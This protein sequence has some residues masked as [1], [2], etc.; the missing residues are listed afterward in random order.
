MHI[1]THLSVIF[2]SSHVAFQIP[3]GANWTQQ[4]IDRQTDW[5]LVFYLSYVYYRWT[6]HLCPGES[7]CEDRRMT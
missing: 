2:M 5:Y 6:T 1:P 7:D 3:V 4:A